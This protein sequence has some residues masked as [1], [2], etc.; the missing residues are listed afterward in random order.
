MSERTP[1]PGRLRTGIPHA[2]I[3]LTNI[4]RPTAHQ[5]SQ[6][7]FRPVVG[8][9]FGTSNTCAAWVDAQGALRVVPIN[10]TD[11]VMPTAIWFSGMQ[12]FVVGAGARERLLDDPDNVVHGFKRFLGRRFRSD[13]V[14]R[15]RD[16]VN[17]KLVEGRDGKVAV[18]VHGTV[19]PL[20][21]LACH[22]IQRVAE[23]ATASAGRHVEDCVLSVPA[24]F[25]YEQ[26][27]E[28]R[29]A[30]EMAGLEVRALINEPTAAALR[31][32]H[33]RSIRGNALVYDLGGG[34]FDASLIC[35]EGGVVRVLATGGDA[36]LGGAD[37]DQK[38]T[39]AVAFD[40]ERHHGVDL[41]T[42]RVV[43]QRLRFACELAKMTLSTQ[44]EVLVRVPFVGMNRGRPLDVEYL[45]TR[46]E[47]ELII[48]PLV[49][50]TM[51]TC[52][53]LLRCANLTSDL[54]GEVILVGGQTRTPA[55][56]RRVF[57]RFNF[58]PA[59]ALDP[60]LAVCSGAALLGHYLECGR[61][62]LQDVLSVPVWMMVPGDGPRQVIAAQT[63][64]PCSRRVTVDVTTPLGAPQTVVFFEALEPTSPDR[65]ILGTLR[66]DPEWCRGPAGTV[67]LEVRMAQNF[68]LEVRVLGG[69]QPVKP[70]T[71]C[72]S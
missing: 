17:Y 6:P 13:F 60:E 32:A 19:K 23:L 46:R 24:H 40:F 10:G 28:V 39:H 30:A 72:A 68:S 14:S 57:S 11:Y 3:T 65:T 44:E 63:P 55:V 66:M 62:V 5:F 22:V 29:A 27:Q 33:H 49:E 48:A 4:P 34:T 50:R 43:L 15:H 69:Q 38:I 25:G 53:D 1:T 58:D 59:R 12:K 54:V 16:R 41:T 18:E 21:E 56:R 47:L 9:D 35:V 51:G 20:R 7:S 67:D 42:Q 2:P 70:L 52:D 64:V 71:L 45:L 37:F 36:F 26:R 61:S 31:Y 8:I